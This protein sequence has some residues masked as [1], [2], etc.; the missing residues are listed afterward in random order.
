MR[1]RE[2]QLDSGAFLAPLCGVTTRPFRRLCRRFGASIVFS[3]TISADGL[4]MMNNRTLDMTRFDPEERPIGIQ[5][6]GCDPD[7][8]AL[9][10]KIVVDQVNPDVIDLN[11]G[12]PVPKFVKKDKGA[13]LLRD[14]ARIKKIIQATRKAIDIP[15]TAKMRT[16]WDEST[17]VVKEVA[18]IADGEGVDALSIHGRTRAQGYQGVANWERIGDA[19]QTVSRVP[20]I[21]NGDVTDVATAERRMQETGCAAVMV[22]RGAIGNPWIFRQIAH[23]MQTGTA[24]PDPTPRERLQI[25]LEHLDLQIEDRDEQRGIPEFRRHLSAYTKGLDGA[26]AFRNQINLVP[27]RAI[28]EEMLTE[29]FESVARKE[30]VHAA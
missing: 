4:A 29:F 2:I 25:C 17:I 8:I 12:C 9:A 3:E 19:V 7:K 13:A 5:I 11:F 18:R 28:L 10:A 14:T 16:G 24:L 20:I 27:T 1:I 26:S 30:E 6:F 23:Y 15:L 22:G 21:G